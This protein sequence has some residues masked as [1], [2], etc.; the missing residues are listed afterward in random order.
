MDCPAG[1]GDEEDFG[2]DVE[3]GD[4]LPAGILYLLDRYISS[5]VVRDVPDYCIDR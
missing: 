4:C 5:R 2:G 1:V 3:A